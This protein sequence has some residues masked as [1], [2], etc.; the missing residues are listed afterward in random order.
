MK[1]TRL[2]DGIQSAAIIAVLVVL[3]LA[4]FGCASTRQEQT[5]ERERIVGVQGGQPTDLTRTREQATKEEARS[6][7]DTAEVARVAAD[8]TAKAAKAALE[9]AIPGLGAALANAV[10]KADLAPVLSS[11]AEVQ[12]ATAPKPAN[13]MDLLI[14]TG[15]GVATMAAG[16][17]AA[18]QRKRAAEH[19]ERADRNERHLDETVAG[20]E[21]AKGILP[22]DQWVRLR[23]ALQTRQSADT[24]A[25]IDSKTP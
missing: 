22:A 1:D 6:T 7:V 18:K 19:E 2:S 4:L 14:Q 12:K 8:A 13:N 3:A 5:V 20:I 16:G 23:N 21:A 25:H 11:L 24:Q 17:Y 15:L 9:S 10:P